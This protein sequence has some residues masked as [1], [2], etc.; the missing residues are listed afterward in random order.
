MTTQGYMITLSCK[1]SMSTLKQIIHLR[2][3]NIICMNIKH[4]HTMCTRTSAHTLMIREVFTVWKSLSSSFVLTKL[5]LT[6]TN[7]SSVFPGQQ[8]FNGQSSHSY[9]CDSGVI[10]MSF[11]QLGETVVCTLT[12]DSHVLGRKIISKHE[13]NC[14]FPSHLSCAV[15]P[16]VTQ[17]G[18]GNDGFLPEPALKAGCE[19]R[20]HGRA[21]FL[22]FHQTLCNLLFT[23]SPPAVSCVI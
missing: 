2:I 16:W 10:V 19:G 22:S 5:T 12:I 14:D 6:P 1:V 15:I 13:K 11:H 21:T 7:P 4:M 20:C 3:F 23:A 18:N 17:T 8:L 9:K